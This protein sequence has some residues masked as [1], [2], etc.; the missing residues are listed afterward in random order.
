M[1]SLKRR[2]RD[3]GRKVTYRI[4]G[5]PIAVGALLPIRSAITPARI[6]RGAYARQ[7]WR[8]RD[9]AD[10]GAL[11]L[12]LVLWP[13][14]LIG[15]EAAFL[16]KNGSQIALSSHR[17]RFRQLLD[18]TRLYFTA[19]VLPPWYYMFELH[20]HPADAF[21]R[22]FIYRWESKGGVMGLLKEGARAPASVLTDKAEFAR[23]CQARGVAT[24]PL[25][26]IVRDGR[27]EPCGP[28]ERDV[29]VKP[30]AG[31][32]GKGAERWD[33]R[34]GR[35]CNPEGQSLD[36]DHLIAALEQRSLAG[37]LIVQP[38][39]DSHPALRS[40]SNGALTTVRVLTCLDERGAP[41]LVGAAMR[42]A[43]GANRTV[44]NL[45]AGGIAAAVDLG[46][47][48]LGRA[49]DIGADCR[50]GWMERHPDS[51]AAIS[52]TRVPLWAEIKAL[53]VAA[54]RAFADRVLIGWDIAPT[55]AGAVVI[56]GNGAP[57][58]D[59]MQRFVRHGLMAARLGILL[60]YHLSQLDIDQLPL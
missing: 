12:A 22:D 5:L 57:D 45:H 2:V 41:E 9:V 55:A 29:F 42:M 8:P 28:I 21:A 50:L 47:G 33:L 26:A 34:L 43:I 49:S 31:R 38:R 51:G 32:G 40:L 19:G 46:T 25:L 30:L 36:R 17:S 24:V 48:E 20:R 59:I 14:A 53:A 39:L 7:F 44:D 1:T 54:H 18:Q 23:Q 37:P 60:A 10:F 15:L 13:F 6:I 4:A 56:E 35:Y 3:Y 52:G 16:A 27:F 58:L 11:L